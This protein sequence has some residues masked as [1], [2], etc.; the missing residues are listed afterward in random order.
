TL[1][2][3][4]NPAF[5]YSYGF[6][7][8]DLENLYQREQRMGKLFSVFAILAIFISC[9]GLYGLSAFTAE[10]RT[11]EIGVRKVLGSSVFTVVYL[12][13]KNFTRLILISLFI[14]IPF[15]W[16]IMSKWLNEF[17]YHVR[18]HWSIFLIAGLTALATAW[19][20]VAY[21]TVKA[22]VAN[23]VKSMRNE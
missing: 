11:K 13:L 20:T 3:Q 2:K 8:Q 9:L 19:L 14:A 15:S 1:S 21:E 12:L 4:L 23:P 18:I 16:F 22:A 17:A 10:Q 5:P 7:D 6:L